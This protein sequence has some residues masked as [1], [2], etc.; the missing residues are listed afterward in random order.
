MAKLVGIGDN[1]FA[2][3]ELTDRVHLLLAQLEVEGVDVLGD[4]TG[5]R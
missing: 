3:V 4:P 5:I 1:G 2:A